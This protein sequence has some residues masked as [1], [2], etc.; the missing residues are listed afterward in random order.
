MALK[1]DRSIRINDG[2]KEQYV[3]KVSATEHDVI[4]HK[5]ISSNREVIDYD[6]MAMALKPDYT[7]LVVVYARWAALSSQNQYPRFLLR[8]FDTGSG[9]LTSTMPSID[10]GDNLI[11]IKLVPL[12]ST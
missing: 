9:D 7:S 5:A 1:T 11:A 12:R 3:A 2:K 8:F 6:A 10:G 4:W